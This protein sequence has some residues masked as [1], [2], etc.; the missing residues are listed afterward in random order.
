VNLPKVYVVSTGWK[1]ET[2]HLCRASVASQKGVEVEHIYVEAS[3]QYFPKTKMENIISVVGGLSMDAVVALVDGDDWLASRTALRR[4]AQAHAEGFWVT[5][6]S[7]VNDDG[8]PG[9][10]AP[11]SRPAYRKLPWT[12]THLKTVRAGLLQSIRH[13]DLQMNEL[14]SVALTRVEGVSPPAWID[15]A[16]DPA[17]MYPCLEMA[18]AD[19]VQ[20]IRETLYVYKLSG[21][22]HR[23]ASPKELAHEAEI[24]ALTRMR[25]PYER[26]ANLGDAP[27]LAEGKITVTPE[28]EPA[29]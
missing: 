8:S 10:A 29:R 22:W 15:R 1:H 18:G 4:I 12:A 19:R 28:E 23:S 16:D 2:A 6:G 24:M 26:L 20:F 14:D 17:F 13:E 5:F 21:A 27:R 11:Y 25:H 7:F 9:F 3:D